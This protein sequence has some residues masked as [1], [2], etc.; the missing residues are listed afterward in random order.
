MGALKKTEDNK[1]QYN[2]H[3]CITCRQCTAACPTNAIC[4]G[5]GEHGWDSNAAGQSPIQKPGFN[6]GA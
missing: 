5:S 3:H 2:I 6:E 1:I 4:Y